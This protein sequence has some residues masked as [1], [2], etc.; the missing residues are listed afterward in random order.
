MG[1][2]L[3][4]APPANS[5]VTG[6]QSE[7]I[8]ATSLLAE[9][10]NGVRPGWS[11][12]IGDFFRTHSAAKLVDFLAKELSASKEIYPPP[13]H[14][15]RVFK[16]TDPRDV[17]VVILGQ[18]PYHGPGQAIGLSFAVPQSLPKK[19][20]SLKNI[21]KELQADCNSSTPPG[22]LEV[23]PSSD[24]LGWVDQGVF[25][26]NTV[27]TVEK[28][29]PYSHENLG[30]QDLTQKTIER[31]NLQGSPTVF[32]LWGAHA[33][34]YKNLINTQ[35]HLIIESVHPSPLSAY[36]GFFGSRPFSRANT[37]LIR[38]GRAPIEWN[39]ISRKH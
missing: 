10:T 22:L 5:P 38:S 21:L 27:L 23:E 4:I 18:D 26:L 36:R 34:S 25:L 14:V 7:S 28:A 20:P 6:T 17:R 16:E 29:K 3:D 33:Q 35:K 9:M 19:P 24:L 2:E 31:I 15:L 12:L 11:D 8:T 30:W 32:I 39:L 37:F 13:H 1:P